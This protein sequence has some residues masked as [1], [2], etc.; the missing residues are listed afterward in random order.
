MALGTLQQLTYNIALKKISYRSTIAF[1]SGHS[2]FHS[3]DDLQMIHYSLR[4]VHFPS[5]RQGQHALGVKEHPYSKA[6]I[7]AFDRWEN[8]ITLWFRNGNNVEL[9]Q[10][11][12][13]DELE[14]ILH[15]FA[16]KAKVPYKK[17]FV[18]DRDEK[19][20]YI[21]KAWRS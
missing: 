14:E 7:E 16:D 4:M 1:F 5:V 13:S 18:D 3:I 11:P 17:V 21:P 6:Q 19:K 12:H 9:P 10:I 2:V 20:E 8:T 15:L